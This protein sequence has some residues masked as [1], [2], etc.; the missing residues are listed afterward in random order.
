MTQCAV[1]RLKVNLWSDPSSVSCRH[2][3][4]KNQWWLKIRPIMKILAKYDIKLDT[5]EHTDMEHVIKKRSPN[6][7]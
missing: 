3:I 1:W 6:W 5:S 2:R 4:P 7:K